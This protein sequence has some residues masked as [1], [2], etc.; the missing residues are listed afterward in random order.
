MWELSWSG[1]TCELRS[2]DCLRILAWQL[3]HANYFGIIGFFQTLRARKCLRAKR[4][5]NN[6]GPNAF[7]LINEHNLD[8][9]EVFVKI[10][11]ASHTTAAKRQVFDLP[12]RSATAERPQSSLKARG[13]FLQIVSCC[14]STLPPSQQC[15]LQLR[16]Q[17]P[18][19]LSQCFQ[20]PWQY[21]QHLQ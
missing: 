10:L 19:C 14:Q 11:Y 13:G 15:R 5:V 9:R 4:P 3:V 1:S 8:H 17:S 20:H 16:Q 7:R 2:F 18:S 21:S 6:A 12:Y